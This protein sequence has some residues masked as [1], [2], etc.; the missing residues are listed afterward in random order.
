MAQKAVAQAAVTD[1][2]TREQRWA[3]YAPS[4]AAFESLLKSQYASPE[5]LAAVQ[6]DGA[7]RLVA[8]ALA[9]VP[10]YRDRLAMLRG[11]DGGVDLAR[12][13]EVPI[14][15]RSDVVAH[16]DAMTAAV[17]PPEHGKTRVSRS[18]G[19][20]GGRVEVLR[21]DL[22]DTIS[23]C[24]QFRFWHDCGI[25]Y[26]RNLGVI[27]SVDPNAGQVGER[28]PE[29]SR[30]GP[31]W[32]P[33]SERGQRDLLSLLSPP[34]RQLAWL[35]ERAPVYLHTN[36]SNLL[37]LAHHVRDHGGDVTGIA[38]AI[39]GGDLLT[40]DI[41]A[42]ARKWLR[43]PV[44]DALASAECGRIASQ[45]PDGGGGYHFEAE[46]AV[47]EVLKEDGAPC[48]PGETG[49]LTVSPLYSHAMPLIRYQS[50]DW[51]TVGGMCSCGRTLPVIGEIVGR[52]MTL[53]RFPDRVRVKLEPDS[54]EIFRHIGPRRWQIAQTAP[55]RIEVRIAEM[56]VE[57]PA[58]PNAM[59]A[60]VRKLV[61][62]DLAI[63]CVSVPVL[64]ST[65]GGKVYRVI[66]E[67]E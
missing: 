9:H 38:G 7:R 24:S 58:N 18:S 3:H 34:G 21:T 33:F 41:R 8:H 36:A 42:Q 5:R 32:L 65:P 11:R 66:R 2:M 63:E 50:D 13:L 1:P 19:T 48:R 53:L 51:V 16:G 55:D 59:A 27:R 64:G 28:N 6:E 61:G 43:V 22:Q 54:D 26:S 15:T 10:F 25:D 23:A 29:T 31:P 67:F 45:C 60:Y 4:R 57:K 62:R 56:R 44:Y 20:T 35:A 12:W 47:V 39:T 14:L 40:A 30:W 46:T 17:V 49:L 37:V 52:D